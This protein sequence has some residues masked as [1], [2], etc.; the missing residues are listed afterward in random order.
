MRTILSMNA[1]DPTQ[2]AD[3]DPEIRQETQRRLKYFG[4]AALLFFH[5]PLEI[6]RGQ[7]AWL[8][9]IKGEKYL[10]AYNNVPC[11]GHAHPRVAAYVQEQ[12][13]KV[14]THTRYLTKIVD[15]YAEKLLATFPDEL[16]NLTMTCTGSESNDLALRE[17]SYYT[18]GTGV[19][20]TQTAY[21]GNSYLTTCVSPSSFK[22]GK[23]PRWVKSV[24]MPDSYRLGAQ[25][26]A[27]SFGAAVDQAFSEMEEEGIKPSA[28]LFDTIFSSDGVFAD[29][30]GFVKEAVA[31]ARRHGALVIADEVQPGFGRTGQ[32]WGFAR[33]GFVPDIV[34]MGKPMG[35]GYPMAGVVTRPE[36]LEALCA[37][38]GYFNTFG[39][40]PAAAAAGLAVIETIFDEDLLTNAQSSG[41]ALRQGLRQLQAEFSCLGDV[42]GAGLF[43]GLEIVSDPENKTP[44]GAG[45]AIIMNGLKR[46]HVLIGS[47]GPWGSTLKIRPPLCFGAKEVEFFLEALHQTLKECDLH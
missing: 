13:L 20:V 46:H 16:C 27:Q 19:V 26:V 4:K 11:I 32:M 36:I 30:V 12:L 33:Q 1:F 47:A 38:T 40:S 34:T 42:R 23:P 24:P 21:H 29:P 15:D 41:D 43:T 44:D 2:L 45:A 6:E 14:N 39:G 25:N 22:V 8:Y 5:E 18:G 7:G 28:L 37:R 35:N 31:A 17:A 9:D 3:I 10:D